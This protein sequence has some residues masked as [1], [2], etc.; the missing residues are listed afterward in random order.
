MDESLP[1]IYACTRSGFAMLGI[2][3]TWSAGS[4]SNLKPFG[5]TLRTNRP[6]SGPQVSHAPHTNALKLWMQIQ[7]RSQHHTTRV[8]HTS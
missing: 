6:K 5:G 2:S 7:M 8:S 1:T 3:G 4:R